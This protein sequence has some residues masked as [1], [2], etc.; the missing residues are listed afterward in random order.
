MA[1]SVRQLTGAVVVSFCA[2]AF[3][4]PVW[5]QAQGGA[6]PAQPPSA[7]AQRPTFL[8]VAFMRVPPG[9][10]QEWLKVEQQWKSM[11]TARVQEGS[12]QSWAAIEQM[13]PGDDSERPIYAT[14]TTYREWP[15]P[16]KTNWAGLFKKAGPKTADMNVLMQ[17]TEAA[18]QV[19]RREIWAVLDQTEP[20]GMGA[21]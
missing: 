12:I 2:G 3:M 8:L 14:V 17:Q 21:K 15:D 11:H 9:G 10:E 6:Q 18:R 16:T 13:V 1:I 4:T 7:A 20:L 5:T 19:V